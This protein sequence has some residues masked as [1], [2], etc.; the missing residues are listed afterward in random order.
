MQDNGW[1]AS[2]DAWI[3]EMG[4]GGDFAR[5]HVLDGPMLD[6][7][8]AGGFARA[9]DVGSGEGRLCRAMQRV[10]IATVGVEP[11]AKLRQAAQDRDPAG[12]YIDAMAEDLPFADGSFDLVVSCLTL[13]DI[14]GAEAAI[15]EFSRV[16]SPGGTL[17]IANLNSFATA[18]G[19]QKQPD[20]SRVFQ[21][22]DYMDV[23]AE[24]ASWRQMRI[25]NWHR[26]MSLYMRLL[27][28]QGLRLT[29]FDEPQ[30]TGGDPAVA[31]RYRRMPY[32]HIMVWQKP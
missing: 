17:I 32:F 24:W 14:D 12:S 20:G 25:R 7:I 10:G 16:M 19:W 22:D 6:L 18:G 1:D 9:L 21:I 31:D 8:G 29:Y 28:A 4:E 30:P 2:A 5:R 3:T 15:A 11:T 27:L 13:I 26:P 23:R